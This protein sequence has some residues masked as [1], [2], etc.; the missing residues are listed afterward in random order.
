MDRTKMTAV[1]DLGNIYS[2]S[3]P[4]PPA[5]LLDSNGNNLDSYIK[6]VGFARDENPTW[7]DRLVS[8][9]LIVCSRFS[10]VYG[11]DTR[12]WISLPPNSKGIRACLLRH[13]QT[14]VNE[15]RIMTLP[16]YGETADFT[17]R[18]PLIE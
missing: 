15:W 12:I 14:F 8:S 2:L 6:V 17:N 10:V 16:S 4:L 9:C 1:G 7:A 13:P 18:V 5:I 3:K 11:D